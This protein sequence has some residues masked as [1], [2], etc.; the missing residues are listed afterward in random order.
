MATNTKSEVTCDICSESYTDPL[1]L[2]C[3]H[4][5][6]KKCLIKRKEEQGASDG[7]LRCPTCNTST[8]LSN[9]RVQGLTQNCWLA[10]QVKVAALKDKMSSEKNVPCDDCVDDSPAVSYC[11]ECSKFLCSFCQKSHQKRR[12]TVCHKLIEIGTNK[13]HNKMPR[14]PHQPMYCSQH[15]DE[16]FKFYCYTCQ[17]LVCRD[18]IVVG[19]KD[20]ELDDYVK[21]TDS[22]KKELKQCLTN[23]NK[24]I[25]TAEDAL[26][27]GNKM[28]QLIEKREGEV[29]K[30]IEEVFDKLQAILESRRKALLNQSKEIAN[31]KRKAVKNQLEAFEKLKKEVCY[32]NQLTVAVV[33]SDDS[34]EI[35]SISKLIKDQLAHCFQVFEATSFE[36]AENEKMFTSLDVTSMSNVI[37]TFGGVL[38]I[39]CFNID[40]AGLAVPMATVGKQRKFTVTIVDDTGR[41]IN[42]AGGVL[43]ASLI[44]VDG[45]KEEV[46]VT[47]SNNCTA[48]SCV[49]QRVGQFELSMKVGGQHIKGSPYQFFVKQKRIYSSMQNQCSYNV[50]SYTY[51]VAVGTNGDVYASNYINGYIEVFNNNGTAIRTIGSKGNGNGQFS[52]PYGLVLVDDTLY[53]TDREL[54]RVQIFS[55]STGKYIGQFGSNGAEHGQFNNPRGITYNGKGHILV[56]DY[57]NRRVQVFNMD[58]TFLQVIDCNGQTPSDVAVDNVGNIHVTYHSRHLVQVFSPD[59]ITKICTYSNRNGNFNNPQGITIDDDGY[60]FITT[61]NPAGSTGYLHV[62]DPTGNEVNVIGGL[63]YPWGVALDTQGYVY[64]AD[65]NKYCVMKY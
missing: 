10:H 6:C 12:E 61:Y 3:L 14:V 11:C 51:G 55:G 4:S 25:D 9:G 40:T 43:N 64:V 21:V 47:G 42:G 30:E 36:I 46:T 57:Y 45:I 28:L 5:F 19:H 49:P 17:I 39:H 15:T 59:G 27:N 58:G 34:G 60:C 29:N 62:L 32:A 50:G 31:K 1:M 33:E 52:S 20:H 26:A 13:L 63:S 48:V 18:C 24:V 53:V 56:A 8:P 65:C 41:A 44:S 7:C 2:R 16:K 38:A 22:S 35:L 23:C 54:H 37:N